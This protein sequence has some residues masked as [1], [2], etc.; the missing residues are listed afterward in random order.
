MSLPT[1]QRSWCY[2]CTC[3]RVRAWKHRAANRYLTDERLPQRVPLKAPHEPCI[4]TV[5]RK[6]HIAHSSEYMSL[7]CITDS[8]LTALHCAATECMGSSAFLAG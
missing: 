6:H 4:T 8:S 5:P 2:V 3:L 1:R 7:V